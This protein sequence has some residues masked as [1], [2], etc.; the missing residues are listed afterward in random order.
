MTDPLVKLYAG[1]TDKERAVLAYSY[2]AKQNDI[3]HRRIESTMQ[4]QNFVG[5]PLEYRR[6]IDNLNYLA[7]LYA[8]EYWKQV[9]LAQLFFIGTHALLQSEDPEAYRPMVE[10]FEREE[11][12]LLSLEQAFDAVCTEHGFDA[13]TMRTL[14]GTRFYQIATP[15]LKA[16]GDCLAGYR[17]I[18]A[19]IMS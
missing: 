18:F 19:S 10:R 4:M 15:D 3:E 6:E 11:G 16:S 12:R 5:L 17:E 1:L 14:S 8:M 9:A 2:I 7:L 13:A